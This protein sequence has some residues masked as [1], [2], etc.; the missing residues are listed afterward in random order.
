MASCTPTALAWDTMQDLLEDRAPPVD[1][2]LSDITGAEVVDGVMTVNSREMN[3]SVSIVNICQGPYIAPA[4]AHACPNESG[5]TE[6]RQE[7]IACRGR[8]VSRASVEEATTDDTMEQQAGE[9]R[10]SAAARWADVPIEEDDSAESMAEVRAMAR[11]GKGM[12]A[13]SARSARESWH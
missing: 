4:G 12:G 10:N 13:G 1:M 7:S 5:R 3:V 2:R 9:V 6:T 11:K 8:T